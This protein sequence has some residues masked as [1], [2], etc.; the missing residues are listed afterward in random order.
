MV[1][2]S[3]TKQWHGGGFFFLRNEALNANGFFYNRDGLARAPYRF[4][5][6][7]YNL[8]GP[9]L[10]PGRRWKDRMFFFWSQE[11]TPRR[12]PSRVGN[13]TMPTALER[14]GDFSQTLD[15]NGQLI[16]VNDPLNGKRPFPGN[17]I[18]KDRIDPAGQGL[19]KLFPHAQ[20]SRSAAYLQHRVPAPIEHP[21]RDD[22]VRLDFNLDPKTTF[23]VRGIHDVEAFRG[24]FNF[25]LASNIWPQMGIDYSINSRG[26]VA[27]LIRTLSPTVVNELTVGMNH[28]AQEVKPLNQETLDRNDRIK[29]GV[30]FPQVHP[31]INP[32]NLIPNATFGGVTNAPQFIIE[33]RFPFRGRNTTWNFSDNLSKVWYTHTL[34][35]GFYI[36]QTRR[37][38]SR[39]SQFNGTIN[40]DRSPTRTSTPTTRTPTPSS[41]RSPATP[42]RTR[43]RTPMRDSATSNGSC[44][45]TGASAAASRSTSACVSTR[46]CR[47]GCPASNW[48][49]SR[50]EDYRPE[51]APL[52]ILPYRAT[53]T[54]ARVG[55]NPVTKETV[56]E[57]LIGTFVPGSGDK[58]NG[59]R[60]RNERIMR[61][62]ICTLHRVSASRGTPWKWKDCDPWRHRNISRS[63]RR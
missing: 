7:G 46:S 55:Y 19:L 20:Y 14:D 36:E 42:N 29:M 1:I 45:T 62:P 41:A 33:A 58:Y 24:D 54:A 35:A 38:A 34:K 49:T 23:Y 32:Y 17:I 22:V 5:S 50:M 18:P 59:M 39:A 63:L 31:E 16:P 25:T 11:W 57:A 60:V 4:I 8:G 10:L 13:L 56:S 43:I 6:P 9:V 51:N 2:K 40:F 27:T 61:H 26:V 30:N 53:P 3:G 28:A 37:D 44:R 52:L 12:T 47:I 48:R 15:L 21:R